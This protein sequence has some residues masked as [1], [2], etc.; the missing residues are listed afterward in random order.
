MNKIGKKG[1]VGFIIFFFILIA[2]FLVASLFIGIGSVVVKMATDTIIPE[3]E[4][5]GMVGN[6]NITTYARYTTVPLS[7]LINSFTWMSGILYMTALIG[8][9]VLAFGYRMTSN[10]WL[11]VFF[12]ALTL[13]LILLSIFIS[14]IYEDLYTGNDEIGK[15]LQEHT[16][17]SFLVIHSPFIFSILIFASGIILF[18]GSEQEGF[19]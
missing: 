16:L 12:F 11:I 1:Q 7:T 15:G 9:F 2:V 8:L 17:L 19:V 4:N 10:K 5:I 3:V 13:L 6:A 14:N 18:T